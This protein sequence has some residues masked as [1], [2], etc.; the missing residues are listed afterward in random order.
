MDFRDL[1]Y[2]LAIAQHQ[3]ITRAAEALYVSQPTLSKFLKSLETIRERT[4]SRIQT[5]L[6][7]PATTQ[8][9]LVCNGAAIDTSKAV[10]LLGYKDGL[11]HEDDLLTR[12]Q[13]AAIIYRL[14][15]DKSIAIYSNAELTFD[16]IPADAWCAQYVKAMQAAGI[17]NGIGNGKYNPNGTVTW[18]HVLTIF[19]RFVKPQEYTLQLINYNGWAVK[20]VQTAVALG[21]IEDSTNFAPD[22]AITRGELTRL[23]NGVLAL[24]Q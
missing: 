17:V 22:A 7:T 13:L 23:I 4:E 6:D 24:Y 11:L 14:L 2:V 8:P 3:N 20:S 12:A 9:P 5:Q 1:S 10:V 19:S 15:D 21:W 18:A 16:D